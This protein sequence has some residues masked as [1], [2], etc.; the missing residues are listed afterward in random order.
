MAYSYK[1]YLG[2]D[3][4]T[5]LFTFPFSYLSD[6]HIS[7]TVD[8]EPVI[9]SF[10]NTGTVVLAS[11]PPEGST[12]EI[13]RTTPKDSPLVDFQDGALLREVPLDILTLFSLYMAQEVF[14]A[15]EDSY[16]VAISI[17]NKAEEALALAREAL[18]KEIMGPQGPAGQQGSIGPQGPQGVQGPKGDKGDKGD[19][20]DKGDKGDKGDEGSKGPPG[21]SPRIDSIDCGAAQETQ[22]AI[23]DAGNA[24][25]GEDD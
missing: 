15:A 9:F 13:R 23:I 11:A 22:V 19:Q 12:V 20:G 4:Q 14:D 16:G 24:L 5:T 7:V 2:V 17:D 8:G 10:L 18:A 1:T 25:T 21:Q 3:G 6:K